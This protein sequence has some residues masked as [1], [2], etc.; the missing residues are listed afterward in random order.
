MEEAQSLIHYKSKKS[1]EYA[2]FI[3]NYSDLEFSLECLVRLK[4]DISLPQPDLLIAEALF[5]AAIIRLYSCF[6]GQYSLPMDILNHLPKN[7]Q[8]VFAFYKNYRDKHISHRV[9]RFEQIKTG[10]VFQDISGKI[11]VGVG[12]LAMHDA[13]FSDLA[14]IDSAGEFVSALLKQVGKEIERSTV[15]F[16]EEVKNLP[17]DKLEKLNQPAKLVVPSSNYLHKKKG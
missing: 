5:N 12:N 16:L 9:N 1:M 15:E 4:K 6:D 17:I 2:K 11:E 14:F 8:D 3:M 7:A 10:V 13:S